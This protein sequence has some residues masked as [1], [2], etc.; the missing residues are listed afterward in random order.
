MSLGYVGCLC[1]DG[2]QG[3]CMYSRARPCPESGS[4]CQEWVRAGRMEVGP[5]YLS[6][7]CSRASQGNEAVHSLLPAIW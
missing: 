1:L 6:P 3:A 5:G 2:R 7:A 4:V